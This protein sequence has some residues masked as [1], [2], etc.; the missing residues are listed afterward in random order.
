MF[1]GQA[2][3]FAVRRC[4]P[5][6]CYTF[7]MFFHFVGVY[8]VLVIVSIPSLLIRR[9]SRHLAFTLSALALPVVSVGSSAACSRASSSTV[10]YVFCFLL[11]IAAYPRPHSIQVPFPLYLKYFPG[12]AIQHEPT[13]MIQVALV[14]RTSC[15]RD[16][17]QGLMDIRHV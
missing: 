3:S 13:S 4:A 9:M 17:E 8:A 12:S 10:M 5:F 11:S 7:R 2:T 16:A 1:I 6:F 14:P 15:P